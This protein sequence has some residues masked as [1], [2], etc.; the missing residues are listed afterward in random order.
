[1]VNNPSS[2][3]L[4]YLQTL[5][6]ITRKEMIQIGLEK[7]LDAKETIEQSK[8]LDVILNRYQKEIN[9]LNN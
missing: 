9:K 7:G 5:I 4:D 2:N 8:K 6:G 3:Y 1:M